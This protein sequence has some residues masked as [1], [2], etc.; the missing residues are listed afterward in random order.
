MFPL[1]VSLFAHH[2]KHCYAKTKFASQEAKMFPNKFRNIFVKE[3]M[4]PGLPTCFQTFPARE[5][6][7]SD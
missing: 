3:T 1:I 6:L 4:F 5:A 2:R 7:F